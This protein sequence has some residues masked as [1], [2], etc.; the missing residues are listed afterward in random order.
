MCCRDSGPKER[1]VEKLSVKERA[2]RAIQTASERYKATLQR[3]STRM[4]RN[5]TSEEGNEVTA[6]E[7][8]AAENSV[9]RD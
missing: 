2:K 9:K 7:R 4:K 6:D 8:Q 3:K 5:E 1:K